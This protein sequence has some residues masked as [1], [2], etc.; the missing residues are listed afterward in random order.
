MSLPLALRALHTLIII[1][2]LSIFSFNLYAQIKDAGVITQSFTV[3]TNDSL[4]PPAITFC[5]SENT[6]YT[7]NVTVYGE[8]VPPG[9]FLQTFPTDNPLV[10]TLKTL[11]SDCWILAA[12][13]NASIIRNP[14]PTPNVPEFL[15]TYT[16][17][18]S[19]LPKNVTTL[20]MN[21][22]DPLQTSSLFDFNRFLLLDA[23]KNRAVIFTRIRSF[24]IKNEVSNDVQYQ[25]IEEF[26]DPTWTVPGV[27]AKSQIRIRPASFDIHQTRS[28]QNTTIWTI[29]RDS[30][31]L[32]G[33]LYGSIYISLI[34]P[35]KFRPWGHLHGILR[36][37]PIEHIK[38]KD[39]SGEALVKDKDMGLA[40]RPTLDETLG[41]FLERYSL[42][43]YDRR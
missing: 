12:P 25:I 40:Q 34:G 17:D 14:P 8:I 11:V 1:A 42:A 38:N 20:Y 23:D 32:L 27:S 22:F 30:F 36:Y 43:K 26:R 29:I 13:L 35:G 19:Y 6:G 10:S 24:N 16:R 2:L 18:L 4:V 9:D 21:I 15:L 41:V 31:T 33:V 28:V 3:V 7:F 5:I 37:Y 39:V